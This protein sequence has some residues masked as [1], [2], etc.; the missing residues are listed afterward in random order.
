[1]EDGLVL[2]NCNRNFKTVGRVLILVVVED[3]L[4][5]FAILCPSTTCWVL[6][7]VVVEDGLVL[8]KITEL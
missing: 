3:G 6:I 2:D 5:L 1:M 8:T 7:L 4:V